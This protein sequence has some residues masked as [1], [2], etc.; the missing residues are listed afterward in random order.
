[1]HNLPF[2]LK[3]HLVS[4]IPKFAKYFNPEPVFLSLFCPIFYLFNIFCIE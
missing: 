4:V 1:M 3:T 2:N